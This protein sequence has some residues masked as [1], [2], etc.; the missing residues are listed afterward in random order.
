MP[1]AP[2]LPPRHALPRDVTV[3]RLSGLGLTWYDRGA[4]YWRR[5]VGVSLM[6][7]LILGLILL[8]DVGLYRSIR[9]SSHTGFTVLLIIDV[10]LTVAT[11]GYFAIFT[12][13][14]WN[15]PGLP[16]RPKVGA[17]RG[18]GPLVSALLQIGY[19]IAML[20]LAVAFLICPALFLAMF[21][22]SL[23][24]P[25]T[26]PERRARLWVA[27]RLREHGGSTG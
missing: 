3:P 16:G 17:G 14:R 7:L 26:L 4:G 20:V 24:L 5:R 18:R 11:L 2:A 10:V 25:E 13:R 9:H 12:A 21:L 1:N 15:V 22:G 6:W 23:L 27:E 8:I 19:L